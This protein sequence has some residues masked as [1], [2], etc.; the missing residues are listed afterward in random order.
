LQTNLYRVAIVGAAGLKGRE[1]KDVLSEHNFSAVDLK[2][3]DDDESLGQIDAVGDEATFIQ[4]TRQEN[5]EQVDF[6]FFAGEPSFTRQYWQLA[7]DAGSAVIDLS[8]G[9]E[10][11]PGISIRAPWIER[12]LKMTPTADLA[13]NAVAV[14][15]P[16]AVVLALLL[17]R[18]QKAGPIARV[19]AT[20]FE[21]V[22]ERGRRGMDELHEQTVNLLSFQEMP[23]KVFDVQV[24]FNMVAH[25]GEQAVT[26]LS[27]VE[28]RIV[29]HLA[30]I[31]QNRVRVPSLMLVQAPIFHGHIFSIYIELE[32]EM[33]LKNFRDVFSGEHIALTAAGGEE[34]SNVNVAGQEDILLN[35][36]PDTTGQR[37]NAF[38][39]WAAAD[40]LKLNAVTA[41]DCVAAMLL[42]HSKGRVQ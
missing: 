35:V 13:I 17:L 20:V 30:H 4:S 3:L 23:K 5:F 26:P 39:L 1:L 29:Q 9:L 24:A 6:T 37:K 28:A 18:A 38:W 40:N 22:S 12:E 14:A 15:H 8:Y 32:R 2:L 33:S 42:T 41:V 11:E 31:T 21:P 36:R 10:Q 16:A 27:A 34:P 25:Y 19:A 7:R